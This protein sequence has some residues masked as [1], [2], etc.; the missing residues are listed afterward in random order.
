MTHDVVFLQRLFRSGS[1]GPAYCRQARRKAECRIYYI[2]WILNM[3]FVILLCLNDKPTCRF[4]LILYGIHVLPAKS[5]AVP[6]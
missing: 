2:I 6:S 5:V 1:G 3:I 4:T